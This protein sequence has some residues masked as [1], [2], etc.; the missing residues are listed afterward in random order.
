MMIRE[1]V[2]VVKR[3][4]QWILREKQY[5]VLVLVGC[6]IFA[7]CLYLMYAPKKVLSLP[8]VFV[9][10]DHSQLSR[11]M[12]R[13]FLANESF[14][15]AGYINSPN[16][17]PELVAEDRAHVCIVFP[18]GMERDLKAGRGGRVEV[19]VDQSNFLAGSV[20]LASATAV[21]TPFSVVA[22]ARIIEAVDGVKQEQALRR[23][24]PIDVG[25]RMLFNPGFTSNYLNYIPVG[26]AGVGMQ[27][28]ALLIGIRSG[29]SE[30]H[31]R[32]FQ[33]LSAVQASPFTFTAGK[34][35]SY[36]LPLLPVFLITLL[37]PHVLFGAPFVRTG[38]SFWVILVWYPAA[39]IAFGYGLSA[40]TGDPL[41]ST[42]VCALLTLPN[43]LVTGYTWPMF[44]SPKAMLL[45]T[46]VMPLYPFVFAMKKITIWG[47][48]LA[49]CANQIWCLVG[50]SLIALLFAW[51]GTR[52]IFKE[53]PEG[54]E[55]PWL[56]H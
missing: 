35:V 51:L 37:I 34:I 20:E 23:A 12:I 55:V 18:Y 32:A 9:D 41:I 4:R 36:L 43:F 39:M 2:N 5:I 49:D 1:I 46:Y 8:V 52:R 56:G 31:Q 13:A 48:T 40:L 6:I 24:M 45:F 42:E 54:S 26:V 17:F 14:K 11:E 22:D 16:E 3:E 28:C 30:Y 7:L 33:P 29:A 38:L 50:W 53:R 19:M 10:Q 27:L 15:S 44:A 25:T 21:L 47:G